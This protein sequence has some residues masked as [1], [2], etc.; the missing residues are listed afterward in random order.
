MG[1]HLHAAHV[2]LPRRSSS[3]SVFGHGDAPRNSLTKQWPFGHRPLALLCDA[4]L[5][6]CLT[7]PAS[8]KHKPTFGCCRTPSVSSQQSCLLY[9]AVR[10]LSTSPLPFSVLFSLL[11]FSPARCSVVHLFNFPPRFSRLFLI[12]F[13]VPP[14]RSMMSRSWRG[15]VG[16][17]DAGRVDTPVWR[18]LWRGRPDGAS[19]RCSGPS[20][21]SPRCWQ[22]W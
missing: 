13:L 9:I 17:E 12:L 22:S 3:F 7:V 5:V 14:A 4:S 18:P 19:A 20:P 16:V 6:L 2:F 21:P 1:R 15:R 10:N 8:H 11:F